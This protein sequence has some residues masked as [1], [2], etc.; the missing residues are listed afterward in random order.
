M[1][2]PLLRNILIRESIDIVHGHQAFSVMS[3]VGLV[4]A[5]TMGY[6]TC[7]T[8][9]SL[10]GFA[11]ASSI[12]GNKF[13]EFVM[14]SVD[15]IIC[16]SHTCRENSVLRMGFPPEKS[17]VIPNAIDFSKFTPPPAP[18]PTS[19]IVVVVVGRLV[20][21][22]G[23]DL[24]KEVIVQ[25]CERHPQVDFVIAGDGDKTVEIEEVVEKHALLDRVEMIG[26]LPH[27]Q[28]RGA[29]CRGHIFLNCSLTEAFCMAIVEAAAVG[30]LVV[31]TNVGGKQQQQKFV[32]IRIYVIFRV[33]DSG[34]TPS[35]HGHTGGPHSG[36]P[37]GGR[38]TGAP[39]RWFNRPSPR[40]R[41]PQ[42]HLQLGGRDETNRGG[43]PS[44]PETTPG[45]SR[46]GANA[47][48]PSARPCD[49][50]AVG[51]SARD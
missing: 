32:S 17:F 21:R 40:T 37:H 35:S 36:C 42:A 39:L 5:K 29:L 25:V 15:R 10:F 31:S 2:M 49:W 33:R 22:K 50:R 26:A 46:A 11:E 4:H 27:D 12:N 18:P 38:F 20:Y 13:L 16:V 45:N 30:L 48:Q 3:C 47:A 8:T 43:V 19:R 7:F 44:N 24:L 14:T 51:D 23:A 1:P 41:D 6:R 34:S 28:V 9:H